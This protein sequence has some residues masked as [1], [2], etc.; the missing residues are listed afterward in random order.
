[1]PPPAPTTAAASGT[2]PIVGSPERV[3]LAVWPCA[4]TSAQYQRL[5]RYLPASSA[6][7]GKM[8]P[9]LAPSLSASGEAATW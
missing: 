2:G 1:M 3:P 5:A 9:E 8:L 4:Q 6:H 7:P